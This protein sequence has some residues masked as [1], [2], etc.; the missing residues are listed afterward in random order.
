[1][2]KLNTKSIRIALSL[3]SARAWLTSHFESHRQAMIK[4]YSEEHHYITPKL[5]NGPK[6]W[7]DKVGKYSVGIWK[8][9]TGQDSIPRKLTADEIWLQEIE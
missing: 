4:E 6:H 3:D 2:S 1:M 7:Y 9:K 8:T 5:S